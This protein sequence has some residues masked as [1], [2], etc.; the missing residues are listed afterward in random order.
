[1][2][3]QQILNGL[4]TGSIYALFALGFTLIF[5][6]HRLLNLA[7]GGVFMVGAF[8]GYYAVISGL[9][10]WLAA[11]LGALCAGLL[12]VLVQFVGIQRLRR[13][14]HHVVEFAALITTLGLNL[15]LVSAA[16]RLSDAQTVRFPFGTFPIQF[17]DVLGLRISLLQILM[18]VTVAALLS[19]L[20]YYLYSTRAGR[21][22]RAVASNQKAAMLLGVNPNVVFIQTFFISGVMAG[23]AGILIALSFNS[24]DAHMGEPYMLRAFVI[25]VLGGLG[26]IPGCVVA[27]LIFGVIQ[28][29]S[30]AYLPPG[31]P[32]IM[33]YSLLFLV[34]LV[35][36]SG[37]FG[38]DASVVAVGRRA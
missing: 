11:P 7:H 20:L 5:S 4:I 31:S 27:A 18:L 12:S 3:T 19:F 13:Q 10:I 28:T 32:D 38:S 1:M 24:I 35:R 2:L 15:V 25:I 36:P 6:V 14:P 30:I 29:L 8:A 33:L 9:S 22:V 26:S 21:Q 16:Q 37:L 17:Y 23:I 34:L